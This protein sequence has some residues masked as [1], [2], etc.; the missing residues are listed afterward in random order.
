MS[1]TVIAP[2]NPNTKNKI[3]IEFIRV[4]NLCSYIFK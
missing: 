3:F 4:K 2:E 1:S